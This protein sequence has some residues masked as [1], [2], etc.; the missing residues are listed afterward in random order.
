MNNA[1]E[2]ISK[3]IDL[4]SV[5]QLKKYFPIKS[6]LFQKISGHVKAV[7]G[8]SFNI[9]KGKVLGIVGESG[10]GK[11]T[12]GR[13][14]LSLIKPTEGKVYFN[15][16]NIYELNKNELNQIRTKMQIIFQDPYSSL[17]PRLPVYEIVGEAMLQHKIVKNK[18]E[19]M[20]KVVEIISKCGLFEHQAS[21]YP[22]QFSGGQRQRIC[23]AR[24]LAVNPEFIVCDEAVSALDVSIQSQIINLL[25]DAQE[26]FK[27]T[28][29]FISHDLSVVKFISDDVAVMYLGQIV[30]KGSKNQIFNNPLHPYTEALLSAV[31]TVNPT[32]KQSIKRIILKGD[33]PSPSKPPEGCRFHTRCSYAKQICKEILP[34]YKEIENNHF[35]MCHK[36]N[37]MF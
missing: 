32:S 24:A 6:G 13:T 26:D 5:Q 18:N 17:N 7:D 8:I 14:M 35:A 30:E 21:R 34:E 29:L 23:I 27:L 2:N 25:K 20:E 36:A 11:S 16:K 10:C 22:H 33:I 3:N 4:I 28:Y 9:Q 12:L 37:K 31:P 19:M 1:A 15:G